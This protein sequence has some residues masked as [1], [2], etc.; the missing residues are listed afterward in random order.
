MRKQVRRRHDAHVRANSVC[1][2][3]TAIVD[4]VA[5]GHQTREALSAHVADVDRLLALQERSI[6][7]RRAATEQGRLSR[8][9]LREAATLVIRVGKLVHLDNVVMDTMQ[10]P[11]PRSDDELLA[12]ARGLLDRVSSH[13]EAFVAGGLPPEFLKTVADAI[14]RLE[15][16]K[17]AQ[18]ASRQRYTAAAKTIRKTLDETD[19]TVGV[20]ES[21]V[22]NALA[23]PP[24]V[25][26][27]L[28]LAKRVGPRAAPPARPKPAPAPA[29][30]STP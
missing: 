10:L 15:A 28:R 26:T 23:A 30:P 12:Y 24:E 2:E 21:L 20:L 1:T 13:A 17:E 6:E 3:H 11:A 14:Q 7:D 25:L 29:P 27:K 16:A 9:A 5:G 22:I 19:K 8:R 18:A 4:A